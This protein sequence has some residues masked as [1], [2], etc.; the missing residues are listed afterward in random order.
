[1]QEVHNPHNT[2]KGAPKHIKNNIDIETYKD[3]LYNNTSLSKYLFNLRFHEIN[4]CLTKTSKIILS[5][6]EDKRYYVNSLESYG[7]GHYKIT[8][9]TDIN[10]N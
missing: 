10:S 3:S 6:F 8:N 1:M 7:Y 2:L 4:M 9:D 5:A